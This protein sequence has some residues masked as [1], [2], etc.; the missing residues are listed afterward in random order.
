MKFIPGADGIIMVYDVTMRDSFD[1]VHDWMALVDK[2]ATAPVCKLLIGNKCDSDMRVV[3]KKEGEALAR[4]LGMPFLETSAHKGKNVKM[5]FTSMA[6][7]MVKIRAPKNAPQGSFFAQLF[8][9]LRPTPAAPAAHYDHLFKI[10]MIGED[11]VGKTN[12]M[13]RFVVSH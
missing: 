2:H 6:E 12:L 3:A 1:H 11:G 5:A 7:L 9:G 4:D 8:K 13:T 10:V